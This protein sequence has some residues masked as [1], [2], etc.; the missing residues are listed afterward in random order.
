MRPTLFENYPIC[1][2]RSAHYSSR[3]SRTSEVQSFI[4]ISA[5]LEF[6]SMGTILGHYTTCAFNLQD[7]TNAKNLVCVCEFLPQ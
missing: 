7:L 5:D 3:W 6:D 1:H 2:G 4:A